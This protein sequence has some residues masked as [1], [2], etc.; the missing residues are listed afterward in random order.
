M[1]DRLD[2][3]Y[4]RISPATNPQRSHAVF[5]DEL[6]GVKAM[7]EH[8]WCLGHRKFGLVTGLPDQFGTA[9]RDQGFIEA[10]LALGGRRSDIRS[11][12]MKRSEERRVGKEWVSPCRSRWS[13]VN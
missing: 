4:V 3:P 10:I 13:P 9:I 12:A 1:L 6:A 8:L 7:A 5:A 11:V 2:I